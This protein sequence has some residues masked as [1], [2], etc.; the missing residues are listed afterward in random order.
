VTTIWQCFAASG[1]E[2]FFRGFGL[3]TNNFGPDR[4]F[5][6]TLVIVCE[7]AEKHRQ[8]ATG[9]VVITGE[10]TGEVYACYSFTEGD[11]ELA[12]ALLITRNF[13]EDQVL[14]RR[15]NLMCEPAT[16]TPILT[17]PG[18]PVG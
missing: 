1:G 7:E 10:A 3:V 12:R 11:I 13:G 6:G 2:T 5:V 4:I 14:V 9:E 16:K 18:F 17:I 15:A 8:T